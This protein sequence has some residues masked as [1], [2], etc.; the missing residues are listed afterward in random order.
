ME[1]GPSPYRDD[2]R[3]HDE[4]LAKEQRLTTRAMLL[5]LAIC[6]A[7]FLALPFGL[8]PA[9]S[10]LTAALL[11]TAWLCWS[12]AGMVSAASRGNLRTAAILNFVLALVAGG[13]VLLLAF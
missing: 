12:G 10:V 6:I 1:R 8:V 7:P 5:T 9:L 2:D 3:R 13:I 4:W 11:F